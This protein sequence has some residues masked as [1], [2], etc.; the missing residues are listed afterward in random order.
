AG[1]RFSGGANGEAGPWGSG[2]DGLRAQQGL[3][4]KGGSAGLDRLDGRVGLDAGAGLRDSGGQQ[5]RAVRV[6]GWARGGDW[7]GDQHG[8]LRGALRRRVPNRTWRPGAPGRY[9]GHCDLR[10]GDH[11][12]IAVLVA[13]RRRGPLRGLRGSGVGVVG[14]LL[15]PLQ[16]LRDELLD[17]RLPGHPRRR[18]GLRLR[19]PNRQRV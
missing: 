9:H 7:R 18:P 1:G 19:R 11:A 13:R 15:H 10:R 4:V 12:H 6:P 5:G 14:D 8:L 3:R 17:E 16:V 2:D